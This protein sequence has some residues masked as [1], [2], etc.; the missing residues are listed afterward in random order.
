MQ[1]MIP[2]QEAPPT[3]T[4]E[5][6][7]GGDILDLNIEIE[8]FLPEWL[9]PLWNFMQDYPFALILLMSILGYGLGKAI[10]WLLR[11]ILIKAA[12]RTKTDLDDRLIHYLTYVS[13]LAFEVKCVR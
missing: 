12:Q 11:T 13:I 7:A 1:I 9:A 2:K 5:V 10:Q 4:E 3:A 6:V 8:P